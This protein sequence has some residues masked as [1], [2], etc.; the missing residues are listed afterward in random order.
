MPM[1][2]RPPN[3]G[4]EL[5]GAHVRRLWRTD[6]A[7]LLAHLIRLDSDSRRLRFGGAVSDSF[8]GQYVDR[9]FGQGDLMFGAFV[10][11]VL[12]GAAE[13]RS[14]KAI[15]A[16]GPPLDRHIRA[17]AAFSVEGELRKRGIGEKL[18]QRIQ[19]AAQ[20]HGVE[21]IEILC[22]P[23]NVAM[24]RL[25][26]KFVAKFRFEDD[27][28]IGELSPRRPTPY[29]MLREVGRDFVDLGEAALDLQ[30]RALRPHD[31]A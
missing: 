9:C 27:F 18:F 24:R 23:E 15:W 7:A 2:T 3:T 10:D 20:N 1:D 29:S 13:L 6:R 28:V 21:Q 25:A 4:A 30:W 22:L 12:R 11:G 8:L 17:E 19:Q 31:A 16:E 5:P 26:G 14:E